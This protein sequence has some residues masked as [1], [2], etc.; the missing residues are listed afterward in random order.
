MAER[1]RKPIH[2]T[3]RGVFKY[4]HLNKPD[5]GT[6]KFPK[7][8]GEFSVT[9]VLD[10]DDPKTT[11]FIEKI[12]ALMPELEEQAQELFD[13]ASARVKA[14]WKA[15]KITEP[16]FQPFYQDELDED[17][18]PTGNLLFRFKTKA[19]YEDKES[20]QT[21]T[22]VIKL[23]DGRGEVIPNKKRPLVY[24]GT[25]GKVA[26]TVSLSFIPEEAKA[27]VTFYL[28]EVKILKL[29]ASTGG[30][31]AFADD[32]EESDF[33]SDDLEEREEEDEDD[34]PKGKSKTKSKRPADDDLDDDEDDDDDGD[35]DSTDDDAIPF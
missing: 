3:P 16:V 2:L 31:S 17:G 25:E 21:K 9:L 22:K 15:K 11:A 12:E 33:S 32:D 29:A 18:D 4:T 23:L 1:K 7:K 34:K 14:K 5:F 27:F 26:F 6:K 35:D 20:G 28:A 19:T 10:K 8:E 24:S 13:E 30:R